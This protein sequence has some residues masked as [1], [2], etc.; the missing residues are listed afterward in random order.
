MLHLV[1]LWLFGL[2]IGTVEPLHIHKLE[3]QGERIERERERERGKIITLVVC[4][5]TRREAG[6]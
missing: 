2:T 4:N 1:A 3:R 5:E 6:E